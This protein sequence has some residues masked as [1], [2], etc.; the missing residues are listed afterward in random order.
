MSDEIIPPS[1]E[2]LAAMGIEIPAEGKVVLDIFTE[3]C[4][5]CK[6]LSPI[7]EKLVEEG[8]IKLVQAN[9]DEQEGLCENHN[10]NAVP[11][12]ILFKD[13][14]RIGDMLVEDT[15]DVTLSEVLTDLLAQDYKYEI[16]QDGQ[17]IEDLSSFAV[18]LTSIPVKDGVMVGFRDEDEMRAIIEHM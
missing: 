1:A 10:I 16:L 3:W 6:M 17:P 12:L 7:L 8:E 2:D 18:R 9:L 5:P 14:Q 11:T 4:Q 15:E 13:G